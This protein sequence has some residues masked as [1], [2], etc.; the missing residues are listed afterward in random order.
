M[1][2]GLQLIGDYYVMHGKRS[3]FM[4]IAC[5]DSSGFGINRYYIM[6]NLFPDYPEL[7]NELRMCALFFYEKIIRGPLMIAKQAHFFDQN[8][9][10]RS[11]N[12]V[13][14]V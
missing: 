7:Q 8:R 1:Q 10:N 4:Y 5:G 9:K 3:N 12:S 13:R 14:L 2:N 6:E 11:G